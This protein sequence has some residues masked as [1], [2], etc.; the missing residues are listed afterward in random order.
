MNQMLSIV[1]IITLTTS[2]SQAQANR[3]VEGSS[4]TVEAQ[5]VGL[6]RQLSEALAKQDAAVLKRLWSDDLVFTSPNGH[7]TNKTQRLA[8]Q[9]PSAQPAQ[10]SNIND[11]VRVRVYGNTA[12]VTVLTTWKGK[13]GTQEFSDQYQ[14]THVWIKQ[15]GRWQLIA[16]HVSQFKK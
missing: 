12:V 16:A 2:T 14:A 5:L 10:L 9:K 7:L 3:K 11:E 8:G 13:A 6:E 15:R 4:R 1:V